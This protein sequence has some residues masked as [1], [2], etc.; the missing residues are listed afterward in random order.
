MSYTNF[1]ILNVNIDKEVYLKDEQIKVTAT[2][3]NKGNYDGAEVVQ[4]YI[5]KSK[6]KVERALKELKGFQKVMVEK[7]ESETVEISINTKDLAFYDETISD[8]N[9]EKGDYIVYVGNASN[10]ISKELKISIK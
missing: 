10:N 8:W 2:V 3:L 9:L 6:S 5:G 4:V 7:G 1:E